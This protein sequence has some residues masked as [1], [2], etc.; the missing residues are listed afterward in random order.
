MS[1]E[2]TITIKIKRKKKRKKEKKL[3]QLQIK[4]QSLKIKELD[5]VVQIL[6]KI[7]FPMKN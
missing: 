5:R 4:K 2:Q 1:S 6:I 7:V 3:N